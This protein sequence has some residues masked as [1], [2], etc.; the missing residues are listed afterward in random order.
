[1]VC[2]PCAGHAGPGGRCAAGVTPPGTVD[3]LRPTGRAP[4]PP[5][6]FAFVTGAWVTKQ[7]LAS[8]RSVA[9]DMFGWDMK[10][11]WLPLVS[12][13]AL[14]DDVAT[15]IFRPMAEGY[16]PEAYLSLMAGGQQVPLSKKP[17]AGVRPSSLGML[18]AVSLQGA[19]SGR[20]KQRFSASSSITHES[21]Q[22]VTF[23]DGA[24]NCFHAL[25][26]L[27]RHVREAGP[28][29][30]PPLDGQREP[31]CLQALDL[32]DA[33]NAL[34]RRA[35]WRLIDRYYLRSTPGTRGRVSCV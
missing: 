33:F 35:I 25:A 28:A 15:V 30:Q 12:D 8:A 18:G 17:K 13:D 2:R 29:P 32:R 31:A 16:L 26:S 5:D 22:F 10:E 21:Q 23:K 19:S 7:I 34:S 14:M 11:V 4:P 1:M 27:E 3:R 6:R 24:A 9:V 20:A